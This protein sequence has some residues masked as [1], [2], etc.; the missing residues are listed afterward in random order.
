MI[1]KISGITPLGRS[2]MSILFVQ[3]TWAHGDSGRPS[4]VP[5]MLLPAVSVIS[6][7]EL[8][9]ALSI[10]PSDAPA[11]EFYLMILS[12]ILFH[13]CFSHFRTL[14]HIS[15]RLVYKMI[16]Y[17]ETDPALRTIALIDGDLIM[18]LFQ[19]RRLSIER[20]R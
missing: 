7:R 11:S 20:V 3:A 4:R 9:I 8:A 1:N 13:R 5:A 2:S 17:P 6:R 10:R 15:N 19:W 14:F 12:P 16:E 18:I